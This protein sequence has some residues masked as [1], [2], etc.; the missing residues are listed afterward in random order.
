MLF[1]ADDWR[2]DLDFPQVLLAL[3]IIFFLNH[4]H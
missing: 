4:Y 1:W 3:T 2:E